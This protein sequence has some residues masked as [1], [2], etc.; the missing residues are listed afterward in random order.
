MAS[1]I[2]REVPALR[3]FAWALLRDT[4]AADD[5]VQD[6]LVRAVSRWH[7]RRPDGDPKAWLFAILHNLFLNERRSQRSRGA[8][9]PLDDGEEGNIA[10]PL[11]GDAAELRLIWRDVLAGLAV[12]PEEQRSVLLLVGVEDFSYAEAAVLLDVPIGTVMSRL[13][14]G[15]ERLRRLMEGEEG[16]TRPMLKR[17]K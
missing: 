6:C 3:R 12:L 2:E 7:L 10:D 11:T 1:I 17:V 5:L 13:S 15:R 16:P 4:T 9:M 8:M 14:R